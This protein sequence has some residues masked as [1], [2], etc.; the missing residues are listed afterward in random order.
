MGFRAVAV[1]WGMNV[2]Q[3]KA[4]AVWAV[5]VGAA[6]SSVLGQCGFTSGSRCPGVAG[7]VN[8]MVRWDPD[9]AGPQP[10]KLVMGGS[11]AAAGRFQTNNVTVWGPLGFE[12]LG[13]LPGEVS[14]LMVHNG[15]LWASGNFG[16]SRHAARWTGAAWNQVFCPTDAGGVACLASFNGT[17]YAGA[18]LGPINEPRV[19]TYNGTVFVRSSIG[20]MG[21]VYAMRPVGTTLY[22]GGTFNSVKQLGGGTA[23]V[24]NITSLTGNT[25]ARLTSGSSS[26]PAGSIR[27]LVDH[28]G[29][30]FVGGNIDTS[31]SGM[32][33]ASKGVV[34]W[35]IST[36]AWVNI[37]SLDS[38]SSSVVHS[39]T[40][41]GT[42]V[43]AAGTFTRSGAAPLSRA[44]RWQGA[45]SWGPL[46]SASDLDN[47]AYA[48]ASHDG[49]VY[50]GGNFLTATGGSSVPLRSAARWS[51]GNGWLRLDNGFN[52]SIHA[53]TTYGGMLHV[54]GEFT[55]TPS[56]SASKI[57]RN[58]NGVWQGYTGSPI[59]G[60][61]Y[62][63]GSYGLIGGGAQTLVIGGEFA[64]FPGLPTSANVATYGTNNWSQF[65]VGVD[66]PVRALSIGGTSQFM[67]G[68]F[69]TAGGLASES[70]ALYQ[71]GGWF[72]Y[73]TGV[74]D[75][76][77]DFDTF[78]GRLVVGG[79]RFV[80]GVGLRGVMSE[81]TGS[82]WN[83]LGASTLAG[84]VRA[85]EVVGDALFAGGEVV[86]SGS[87]TG[88]L[89]NYDQGQWSSGPLLSPVNALAKYNGRLI[90]AGGA[91][92]PS[93][94]ERRHI[95]IASGFGGLVPLGPM[96]DGDVRSLYVSGNT[97]YFGGE[98]SSDA[99]T[100]QAC[101]NFGS[102]TITGIGPTIFDQPDPVSCGGATVVLSA[103]ASGTGAVTYWWFR[104][105]VYLQDGPTATGSVISGSHSSLMVIT[106]A[107]RDDAGM[108]GVAVSDQC[109]SLLS[110]EVRVSICPADYTCDGF[111]DIFDYE[112]FVSCFEADS[113]GCPPGKSGDFNGDGFP[114][115][116][117]YDEFVAAFEAGC[118]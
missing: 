20:P 23:F 16:T 78:Q 58:N 115:I 98:F 86:G 90:V 96:L 47:A 57:A 1:H 45:Q 37:G 83:M 112:A 15:E 71:R 113:A 79:E 14:S 69:Q 74:P 108:Y 72:G 64:A 81:W 105:G 92:I 36:S 11:F 4:M 82:Q 111:L 51:S 29:I 68:E 53:I 40:S 73:S 7:T 106:G 75:V 35:N 13:S 65:P 42:T 46:G 43:Y 84:P 88:F 50:Y 66:G 80:S 103:A 109:D 5:C 12:Q 10:F 28:A 55:A 77:Y 85:I 25:Y 8:A 63:I 87:P 114:D 61:V 48:V 19:L 101:A 34:G 24:N 44:A 110:N 70:V 60:S 104:N 102:F 21:P 97:V 39:L 9:G 41:D 22:M 62:S 30:L 94:F 116:F 118:E 26:G 38:A 31:A 100:G 99:E 89:A 52:G 27:T 93:T 54:G 49:F 107:D 3:H 59:N 95:A 33:F 56:A 32:G 18:Y 17:L 67:A 2:E 76:V 91:N 6:G 117:D